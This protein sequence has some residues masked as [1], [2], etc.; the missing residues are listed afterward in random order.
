MHILDF[1]FVQ[2]KISNWE[3]I[4]TASTTDFLKRSHLFLCYLHP[5][6]LDQS[7]SY[8]YCLFLWTLK[9]T[10]NWLSNFYKHSY[11]SVMSFVN[12]T[13]M[14]SLF[15]FFSH[16][17]FVSIYLFVSVSFPNQFS[18][19]QTPSVYL[20]LFTLHHL[21]VY[22]LSVYYF[23]SQGLILSLSLFVYLLFIL[24]IYDHSPP[25]SISNSFSHSLS[26]TLSLSVL[27][28]IPL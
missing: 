7:V 3:E 21:S 12:R 25:L 9:E 23:L 26:I 18:F 28:S 6:H 24:F 20:F 19:L 10:A 8:C 2:H 4:I 16:Q 5:H 17:L 14:K 15:C 1:I 11:H 13:H 27:F 22:C